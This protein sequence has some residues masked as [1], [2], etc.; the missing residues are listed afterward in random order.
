MAVLSLRYLVGYFW[1]SARYEWPIETFSTWHMRNAIIL[2]CQQNNVNSVLQLKICAWFLIPL[3]YWMCLQILKDSVQEFLSLFSF[4]NLFK[5]I[6]MC[7]KHVFQLTFECIFPWLFKAQ[8][9]Y[10][11]RQYYESK[12][13]HN[14]VVTWF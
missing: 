8:L 2:F 13:I 4:L 1:I 10:R 9:S 7:R 11:S 14:D 3:K 5:C 6:Y 12:A